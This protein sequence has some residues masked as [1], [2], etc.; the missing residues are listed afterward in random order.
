MSFGF[1][2]AP[3]ES[4]P[5]SETAI[6]RDI[7]SASLGASVV[8]PSGRKR[9]VAFCNIFRGEETNGTKGKEG[10]FK[11]PSVERTRWSAVSADSS[12]RY[13]VRPAAAKERDFIS[14]LLVLW[15]AGGIVSG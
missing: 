12:A 2:S 11:A 13:V 6:C 1:A 10:R 7:D 9:G 5:L 14:C 3:I 15:A 4:K 8:R